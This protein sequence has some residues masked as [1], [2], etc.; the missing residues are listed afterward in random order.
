MDLQEQIENASKEHRAEIKALKDAPED[1]ILYRMNQIE[2][3]YRN[4]YWNITEKF[5]NRESKEEE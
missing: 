4:I 2:R 1:Q 3:K 5:F